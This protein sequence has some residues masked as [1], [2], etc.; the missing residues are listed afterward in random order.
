[1]SRAPL[2]IKMGLG[3]IRGLDKYGF[4][5]NMALGKIWLWDKYGFGQI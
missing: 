2:I 4:G 3:Q 1:M 5:E